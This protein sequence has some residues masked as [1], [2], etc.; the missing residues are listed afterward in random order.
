MN[1]R[2]HIATQHKRELQSAGFRVDGER[3]IR[4]HTNP[5]DENTTHAHAKLAVGKVCAEAGYK[6]DSEVLHEPTGNIADVLAYGLEDRY[7]MVV[8]LET[9]YDEETEKQNLENY[10]HGPVAEVFTL[11]VTSFPENIH[12]MG[13]HAAEELGLER[14]IGWE[15]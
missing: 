7:I 5:K 13:T 4:M 12:S 8:E 15:A 3:V 14:A 11:S 10:Q 6:V 1:H 2:K 9:E